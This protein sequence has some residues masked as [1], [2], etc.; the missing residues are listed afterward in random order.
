MVEDLKVSLQEVLNH[1]AAD[2]Y[3]DML[4][5]YGD[6]YCRSLNKL[7]IPGFIVSNTIPLV[8]VAIGSVFLVNS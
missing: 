7:I 1:Q 2:I 4:K 3:L 5:K 6:H 8:H